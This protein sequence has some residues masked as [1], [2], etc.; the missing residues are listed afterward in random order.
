M[1]ARLCSRQT[2]GNVSKVA[3]LKQ[4][5]QR[6]HLNQTEKFQRRKCYFDF[7]TLA[8]RFRELAFLNAGLYICLNDERTGK[9][10]NLN[11]Q[12]E[13]KNLSVT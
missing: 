2:S 7:A 9:N 8:N 5:E 11:I 4:Q 1:G 6:R 13:F 3:H 12:T 10:K